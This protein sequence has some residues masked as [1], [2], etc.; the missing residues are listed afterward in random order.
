M[1]K[2]ILFVIFPLFLGFLIYVLFRSKNLFYF[3]IFEFLN[4]KNFIL[5]M[6]NLSFLYR[7]HIPNWVIYSL[8]DGLWL[9]SFGTALFYKLDNIKKRILIFTLVFIFMSIFEY[10]QLFF[11]G[12]GSLIGTFD[13]YDLICFLIG[14]VL[15]LVTT[16]IRFYILNNSL[17][18]FKRN[19]TFNTVIKESLP[20]IF[21]FSILAMLPTLFKK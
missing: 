11:G 16:F 1:K 3:H 7:K 10:I 15:V 2:R 12:H 18:L 14:Y 4:I 5:E 20:I 13:K 17:D 9:F 19:K 21:V 6:R 8:P